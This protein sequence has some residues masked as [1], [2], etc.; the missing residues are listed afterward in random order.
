MRVELIV[1]GVRIVV[2]QDAP[3]RV[4][5]GE[6]VDELADAAEL[7]QSDP[8]AYARTRVLPLCAHCEVLPAKK[9]SVYCEDATECALTYRKKRR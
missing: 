1:D 5:V 3:A 8:L 2:E 7:E 4:L 6:I 9:G